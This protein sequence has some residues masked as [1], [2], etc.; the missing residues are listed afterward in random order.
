M[1]QKIGIVASA[2]RPRNWMRLYESIGDNDIEYELV[3]VGPNPPDYELPKNFHFIRSD[4]K[5]TQ[6]LEI[7]YRNAVAELVMPFADDC[8]FA[9]PQPLDRLY[10][11]YKAC[12]D[13]K[14]VVSSRMMTNGEDQSH[15]AHRFFT[16][17]DSSPMMPLAG[18]MSKKFY[19]DLGGVDRNFIAVMWDLDI[20]MRAHA[21]G[22]RVVFS[23]VYLNE[24]RSRSAGSNL[25]NEFWKHDRGLLESLWTTSGKVHFSRKD[26]VE[27]FEDLNI[28][29]VSQGPR[30]RWRGSSPEFL[31]KCEDYLIRVNRAIRTPSMYLHHVKKLGFKLRG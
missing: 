21:S 6:C 12:K 4:V 9:T 25:C 29:N 5:P 18:L 28:L 30:G 8:E 26:V 1:K 13:E 15:F 3:F 17:D 14:V 23:D 22:G 10:D 2:Y 16:D 20:A 24:D 11:C 27:P 19:S 7:A 31:E